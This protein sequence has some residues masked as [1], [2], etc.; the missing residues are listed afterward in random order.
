MDE[1]LSELKA[2]RLPFGKTIFQSAIGQGISSDIAS[3]IETVLEHT[4]NEKK[5]VLE[6]GSGCGIISL[7][8][9]YYRPAWQ[10]TGIEIQKHL[11]E[12]SQQNSKVS[13]LDVRFL[14]Y[15]LREYEDEELYDL[16]ITNPPYYRIN[17]GRISP[18]RERAISRHEVMCELRDVV[19]AIFR[20]LR[21]EGHAY[22]LYPQER[23]IELSDQVKGHYME[24]DRISSVSLIKKVRVMKYRIRKQ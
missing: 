11:S 23:E 13:D 14:H 21:P 20:N 17:A 24:L 5:A 2:V 18:Q 7:M 1:N 9:K 8:L 10:I 15:D 22:L 16:I 19:N 12:I 3:L 4:V 6:L